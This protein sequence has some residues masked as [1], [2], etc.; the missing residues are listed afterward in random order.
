MNNKPYLALVKIVN[1]RKVKFTCNYT[2][3]K[4]NLRNLKFLKRTNIS[5]KFVFENFYTFYYN[6]KILD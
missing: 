5:N 1:D 4:S 2:F 6:I 3:T